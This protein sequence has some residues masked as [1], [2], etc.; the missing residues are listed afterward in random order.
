MYQP[1]IREHLIPR[2]YRQTKA[3]GM[4]MTVLLSQLVAEALERMEKEENREA[5]ER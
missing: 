5:K 3:R 2:L 1:K 4:P